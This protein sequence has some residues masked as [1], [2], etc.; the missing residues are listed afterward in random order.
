MKVVI[1]AGGR[2][3]RIAP[4][5]DTVP[6]PMIPIAGK[7]VLAYE[8]D[9]LAKSGYTDITLVTGYLGEMIRNYFG[10]GSG[11]GVSVSYFCEEEPLGTAG[12]LF[13]M[14]EAGI[15]REDFFL[16]N[17]DI[18]FDVDFKR[19][20]AYHREKGGCATLFTHPNNHPWDS[21]LIVT[22][23]E[24]RVIRWMNREEERT[25]YKNRVNAG[26]HILS[27]EL[28]EGRRAAGKVDLDRDVLK[29]CVSKS[30]IYAY[31]SP[32][33]VRDMG[34]PQRYN[35]V[36]RDFASGK[37]HAKNLGRRQKAVFLD[38]DGTVNRYRG[39][40]R[41]ASE[42]ELIEG[43]ADAVAAINR[44]GYLAIVITNQPV[45][46]RGECTLE[47]LERI[48]NRIETLLGK[49]GAWL[50]DIFFCPHHPD[51]GFVGERPEYKIVC[52]CRKPVPGLLLRAAEKYNIE[53]SESYMVGDEEADILAGQ[54][55][56]CRSV[57]IG[58]KEISCTPF[59][60]CGNLWDFVEQ[61]ITEG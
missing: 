55:A 56:G 24:K 28:L 16:L 10:D 5:T 47:E 60:V 25:I 51:K 40:I 38:R 49:E 4:V 3:T 19:M 8:I 44:S 27:P 50:D 1:M 42:I 57:Y 30:G 13:Q 59:A 18:M 52:G 46:A 15:L 29:P 17:G 32:E 39:F 53:L 34:T 9:N 11:F 43:V 48:H 21:A 58:K 37:I 22:D 54:R 2:G 7:P 45:I 6:K 36:C 20:E 31:D 33:Y 41:N 14:N 61:Y 26:I 12:A 23:E 35:E